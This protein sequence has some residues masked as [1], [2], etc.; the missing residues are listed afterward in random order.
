MKLV[1]A[2]TVLARM[3]RRHL[4]SPTQNSLTRN[5]TFADT[6]GAA[7]SPQ[8]P[9]GASLSLFSS[10]YLHQIRVRSSTRELYHCQQEGVRVC[11]CTL[12]LCP[13]VQVFW[14]KGFTVRGDL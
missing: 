14:P 2:E 1:G 10:F 8:F 6:D 5:N 13:R 11:V 12:Y 9:F 7:E 3:H 4:T